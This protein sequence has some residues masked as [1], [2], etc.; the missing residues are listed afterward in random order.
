MA[1]N[2]V[3]LGASSQIGGGGGG[4]V[5]SVTAS[6]PIASS[7]G[8]NPNISAVAPWTFGV[9]FPLASIGAATNIYVSPAGN[10]ASNGDTPATA[11]LTI[12]RALNRIAGSV[13]GGYWVVNLA[14]GT[15]TESLVAPDM[16]GG[17]RN[18]TYGDSV[19]EILGDEVT[20]TN[21]NISN[22]GTIF[23]I[24]RNSIAYRFRG[25]H[26]IGTGANIG[27]LQQGSSLFLINCSFEDLGSG[28]S[29]S[30]QARFVW[31]LSTAGGTFTDVSSGINVESSS[32]ATI[33]TN[34][35]FTNITGSCFQSTS[36]SSILTGTGLTFT[37]T[38]VSSQIF[39]QS[40]SNG[41]ISFGGTSTFNISNC[42]TPFRVINT[43]RITHGNGSTINFT[44]CTRGGQVSEDSYYQDG[45]T[46]GNTYNYLGTTPTTWL[47]NSNATLFA[48]NSFNGA[49]IVATSQAGVVLGSW[50]K[51]QTTTNV[52]YIATSLDYSILCNHPVPINVTLPLASE[53]GAGRQFIITDITGTASVNIITLLPS[54]ADTILG[55]ASFPINSNWGSSKVE[56]ITGGWIVV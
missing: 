33:I 22:A 21:C 26:F 19:I 44:D 1:D 24:A 29:I 43:G 7:G 3:D 56:A 48:P 42:I 12:G 39:A 49:D 51:K 4:G 32:F 23:T 35:T 13:V 41:T 18:S 47:I 46:V 34:L 54:G 5:A 45:T 55:A 50:W 40:A 37:S 36:S 30:A 14:A 31:E 38:A 9:Q 28:I 25:V 8:A 11:Y 53:V 6:S 2:Y 16:L 15:Y 52:D 27:I 20:P 17:R 10:D